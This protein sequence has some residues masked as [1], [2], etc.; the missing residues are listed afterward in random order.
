MMGFLLLVFRSC[1]GSKARA[2][3][4]TGGTR[5]FREPTPCGDKTYPKTPIPVDY[6]IYIYIYTP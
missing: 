4:G 2:L 1:G 6:G 5:A 3:L